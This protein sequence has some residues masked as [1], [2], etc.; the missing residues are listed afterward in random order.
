MLAF[1]IRKFREQSGVYIS[2]H[3]YEKYDLIFD[4]ENDPGETHNLAAEKPELLKWFCR[5]KDAVADFSR[6]EAEKEIHDKHAELFKAYEAAV[7]YDDSER[8]SGNPETA[9]GQL[10]IA[11]AQVP[12]E[13]EGINFRI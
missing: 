10:E 11:A 4:M 5:A 3:C 12:V 9:R 6:M 7:G 8:W 1:C 2:Y 13:V